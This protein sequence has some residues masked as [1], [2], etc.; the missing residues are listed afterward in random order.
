MGRGSILFL[1]HRNFTY[2]A[3]GRDGLGHYL[4][5]IVAGDHVTSQQL[6][7]ILHR[8]YQITT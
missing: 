7:V 1:D 8:V 6:L 3:Y 4:P 2:K 5:S